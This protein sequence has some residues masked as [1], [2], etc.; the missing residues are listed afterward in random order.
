MFDTD[1]VREIGDFLPVQT[2]GDME[3]FHRMRTFYGEASIVRLD[4]LLLVALHSV[5][6]NSFQMTGTGDRMQRLEEFK[7]KYRKAHKLAG[8]D[9]EAL[10]KRL[11]SLAPVAPGKD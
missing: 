2:R 8:A 3:Y 11:A 5:H 1:V 4:E 7:A 9:P 10:S 6:S